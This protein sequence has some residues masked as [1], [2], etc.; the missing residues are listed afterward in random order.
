[1]IGLPGS[2]TFGPVLTSGFD[3]GWVAPHKNYGI[4]FQQGNCFLVAGLDSANISTISI[5]GLSA[6]PEAITWSG[7]ASVAVLYSRSASWLQVVSGLP[8][9][10]QV[11]ASVDLSS[12]GGSLSMIASDQRGKAM[13]L[14][15]QG[16]NS[17]VFLSSDGQNFVSALPM[18][19]PAALTFA[20]DG[21]SLYILDGGALQLI[22]FGVNDYSSQTFPLV[23]IQ[24]PV[25]IASAQ[26]PQG[27]SIVYVAGA[28]D[29]IFQVYDPAGQ[30]VLAN[31][32]LDFRPSCI[33]AFGPNSFVIASRSQLTDPLWLFASVP[34]PAVYFVPAAQP[35]VGGPN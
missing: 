9:N 11:G 18:A 31:L 25:A 35:S 24:N 10:P 23:G 17:G 29:Q 3:A 21:N 12:L 22:I 27:H 16:A 28:T 5:T 19:N 6:Q 34:E 2:A 20:A 30:Q 14:T 33:A 7:D 13:A 32:P 26:D 4:G 1:M 15:M 8:D